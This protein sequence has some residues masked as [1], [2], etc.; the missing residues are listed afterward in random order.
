MKDLIVF[1][2]FQLK[3]QKAER[4]EWIQAVKRENPNR[5]KWT[6]KDIDS[7]CSLHFVDGIPAKPNPMPTMHMDHHTTR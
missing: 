6:S 7:I 5:T 1:T 3:R 4:H 2:V